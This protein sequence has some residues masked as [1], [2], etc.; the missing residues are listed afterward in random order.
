MGCR[1]SVSVQPG[2]ARNEI[3]G[4]ERD[5][6]GGSD[7]LRVRLT[8]PPIEG[9]ANR[10]L[11]EFLANALGVRRAAVTLV[12]GETSRRKLL[13]IEGLDEAEVHRRLV[14]G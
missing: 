14:R 9:R 12:R 1:L 7:A 4:W 2:A 6:T 3:V 13:A 5:P 8:A 11:I 10:A